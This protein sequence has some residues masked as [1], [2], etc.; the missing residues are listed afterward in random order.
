VLFRGARL[1][2]A[3]TTASVVVLT[4]ACGSDPPSFPT[5]PEPESALRTESEVGRPPEEAR[6]ADYTLDARLDTENHTVTGKATITW[7][8]HTSRSPSSLP[9]HLYMNAFRAEDTA[10]MR[11]ARRSHRGHVHDEEFGWGYI[12]VTSVRLLEEAGV[13]LLEEAGGE[14]VPLS[15]TEDEDPSLMLVEL[16]EKVAPGARVKLE[17]EFLT[18]LPRVF[19]RTGFHEDFFM[20]AQ[21]F[22]KIGVLEE[23]AGWQA[24]VFTVHDEFYADFGDYEVHI[25]V[26]ENMVV[27]A[28]GIRT[29]ESVADGRKLLTYRAEMVHDFA[30]V[31]DPQ[32]VEH[33]G[34]YDGIR[35]RQLIQ[36]EHVADADTH[37]EAQIFALE[38]YE[39]RYGPYP[40]S[41]ITIVHAR[42]GA[43][44]AGGMEYP[45]LYTTSDI[46]RIPALLRGT[47]IEERVS[48]VFTT[49]HEFGHQYFQ[50]LFASNEHL[51]PWLD[52]GIN[53]MANALAYEDAYGDDPWLMRLAGHA[54]YQSDMLRLANRGAHLFD[55]VDRPTSAY[56]PLVH[57]YG[58]VVYTKAAAVMLTL[59]N[60]VGAE[61]FDEAMRAYGDRFRFRHPTGDDLQAVLLEVIGRKVQLSPADGPGGPVFLDVEDYLQQALQQTSEVDFA[62][63]RSTNLRRLGTA[64]WHRDENG[65]L[66]GGEAPEN[67]DD[68]IADLD[69]ED[70]EAVVVVQRKGGF[71][72]PVELVV[73]FED[74]GRERIVWDGRERYHTFTWPGRR[75][76]L[77]M[78]DPDGKLLLEGRRT[79]NTCYAPKKSPD[80]GLEDVLGDLEEATTLAILG[81]LGP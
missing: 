29:Q 24:H 60:L 43:A 22:P 46:A 15:F 67:V 81:G 69:D 21:W 74:D 63:L 49:V 32:F 65:A 23:A 58:Q 38:S 27:G 50:G 55:P 40:W 7:R 47:V 5:I 72:V 62:V 8:N 78:L 76:R 33:Y 52:E 51:E 53:T 77:A 42:H 28:T 45:T 57:A 80:Y 35:I 36:P 2:Q 6:V 12:D 75:L 3:L 13:R 19:A 37:L 39:R 34:E 26:P 64:G 73:E 1:A 20:V 4:T 56:D 48:G 11:G 16:P 71:K 68:K 66:V 44:G 14:P 30:W 25:D 17:I 54:I 70:V 10:W 9:F 59:R 79:D 61:R 41:T 31:A 18:R